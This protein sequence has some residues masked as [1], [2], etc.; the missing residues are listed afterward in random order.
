[1]KAAIYARVS[2]DAQSENSIP[3]QI[4]EC[5]N[6]IQKEG[7]EVYAVYSD[8]A[9]SGADISRQDYRRL[10]SDALLGLFDY[11]VVDD[12]S[13]IGRDMPEFT[14]LYHEL[15]DIGV[16]LIGVADGI[17]T[18]KPSS[19][20][21]V[22]FKGIMNELY[23]DDLKARIVRGL[24]GQMQRGFSTGGRIYG[25][26]TESIF[27]PTG[28]T[29]RF[30]RPRRLGCR[31]SIDDAKAAVVRK[32]FEVRNSGL[33]FKAIAKILNSDSVPSPQGG[34]WNPS[35]IRAI[36]TNR[37]YTGV[38][39]YNKTRWI[40]KHNGGKR[41]PVKNEPSKVIRYESD[42]LRIISS[43]LFESINESLK[44]NKKRNPGGR[45]G[46]LLSGILSCSTCGGSMVVQNSGRYSCYI[47]NNARVLGEYA[48][49]KKLRISR[50][51]L[52]K[53]VLDWL[54][55]RLFTPA[56]LEKIGIETNRIITERQSANYSKMHVL[57]NRKSQLK[58]QI[59]NLLTLAE[60][61][62]VS[63]AL[64]Q[65]LSNREA[66]L[67]ELQS[68]INDS[69]VSPKVLLRSSMDWIKSK[70]YNLQ[71]LAQ[72][73]SDKVILLRNEMMQLFPDKLKV[74]TKRVGNRT[75]FK[76]TGEA[77]PLNLLWPPNL[78][79]GKIAVQGLEPRTRGL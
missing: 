30:G 56:V 46:Y 1:M 34:L 27:D 7:W 55:D 53:S 35:S 78:S 38:W 54:A 51:L 20:I 33:G 19:K 16:N 57:M 77:K 72:N 68:Q 24:K 32:I 2:T 63:P 49:S 50:Q 40:N 64:N 10:R 58:K 11:I 13:R 47:C 74:Y 44:T 61:G 36:I 52:E 23:L 59:D 6:Y 3:D 43:T 73:N 9:I 15:T 45:K 31:I 29:D 69:N 41:K 39:E 5:Q 79:K 42:D 66:E 60:N 18:S 76:I 28:A 26:K 71:M 21:P 48:C 70:L 37:K 25:Y 14:N 12:L 75:G 17:D 8:E 62:E 67:R 65:R 22:Y 4:R